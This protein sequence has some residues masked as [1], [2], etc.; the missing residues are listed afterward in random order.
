MGPR[1]AATRPRSRVPLVLGLVAGV[2][3]ALALGFVL[4][5]A[6]A[7]PPTA[8]TAPPPAAPA[9]SVAA[10]VPVPTPPPAIDDE[11]AAV[12]KLAATYP[13][14]TTAGAAALL[15]DVRER[16]LS[17]LVLAHRGLVA[18]SDGFAVLSEA[19]RSELGRLFDRIFAST[20]GAE[21]G[22]LRRYVAAV[23]AGDL[24]AALGEKGRARLT[25]AVNG[26]PGEQRT[27]LQAL[28][29]KSMVAG[30]SNRRDAELRTQRALL[31]PPPP[32]AQPAAMPARPAGSSEPPSHGLSS[33]RT[34][35]PEPGFAS[36][37][38]GESYW[39]SRAQEARSRVTRAE[40][41]VAEL[42]KEAAG[43]AIYTGPSGGGTAQ[44]PYVKGP[45][46]MLEESRK[47]A[48]PERDQYSEWQD[49]RGATL[50]RLDAARI[51]LEAAKK[52]LTD[53]DD[54]ARR[55]GAL[56]GWLR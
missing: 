31:L 38:Q 25:A 2:G 3:A 53:L 36:Q 23:R 24:D 49:K 1:R 48:S 17:E 56:P 45:V 15:R 29:E 30:L 32:P 11:G 9:V 41:S 7:T 5:R 55:A 44:P 33:G 50:K 12:Q 28:L 13:E 47:R 22:L 46:Q 52:G 39:R 34:P 20:D 21:G 42:E 27:R 8:I 18:A 40:K 43:L 37:A 54:E 6:R 51:S 10:S 35:A 16:G 4:L 19:E 26:L 14:L